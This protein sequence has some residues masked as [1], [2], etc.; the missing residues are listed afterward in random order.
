MT[1]LLAV[2]L[3]HHIEG[4]CRPVSF[5]RQVWA[6]LAGNVAQRGATAATAASEAVRLAAVDRARLDR[7]AAV[8]RAREGRAL[9]PAAGVEQVERQLRAGQ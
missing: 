5:V 7:M 2:L 6:T 9:L 8:E 4:V 1:W 3:L